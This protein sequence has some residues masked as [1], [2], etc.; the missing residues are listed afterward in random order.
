MVI[1]LVQL[2]RMHFNFQQFPNNFEENGANSLGSRIHASKI[3]WDT[4]SPRLVRFQLVGFP[5]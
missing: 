1:I 3:L 5:P 2:S 4:G